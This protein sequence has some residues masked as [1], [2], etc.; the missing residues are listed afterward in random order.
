MLP[1]ETAGMLSE[2]VSL[3]STQFDVLTR[4]VGVIDR[5]TSLKVLG[6]SLA[7]I[8]AARPLA[9]EAKK[10]RRKRKRCK[11]R[12][13]RKCGR[14]VGPCKD[15]WTDFCGDSESCRDYYHNCCDH[16]DRCKGSKYFN[17]TFVATS[18]LAAA[19]AR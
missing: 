11:Q 7:A 17:C 5:K 15:W 3:N 12:V 1:H 19:Q 18:A 9:S 16:L 14:Q 6:G 13:N 4:Q 8:V 10:N 2:E